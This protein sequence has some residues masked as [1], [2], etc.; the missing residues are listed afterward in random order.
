MVTGRIVRYVAEAVA[1][2]HK[3][4]NRYLRVCLEQMKVLGKLWKPNDASG[5]NPT[6]D[7]LLIRAKSH[8]KT[9]I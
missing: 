1:L 8:Q 7:S 4:S 5:P 6:S 3:L 2:L 9:D